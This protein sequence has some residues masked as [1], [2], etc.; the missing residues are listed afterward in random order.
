MEMWLVHAA[1]L[2]AWVPDDEVMLVHS[3]G[4]G[5]DEVTASNLLAVDKVTSPLSL[6]IC[7]WL[8]LRRVHGSKI[9]AA[10]G[11]ATCTF[12]RTTAAPLTLRQPPSAP[13]SVLVSRLTRAAHVAGGHSAAW[14]GQP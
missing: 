2:Q 5:W 13:V 10:D 4:L 1:W 7:C 6:Q 12:G 8:I 14:P 3:F 11:P 9:V